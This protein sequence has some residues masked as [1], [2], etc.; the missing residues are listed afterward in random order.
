MPYLR[1]GEILPVK[2]QKLDI[3]S[4][5]L[6]EGYSFPE[7]MHYVRG[8]M[9]KRDGKSRIGTQTLGA[10]KILHL[11]TFE[12][13]TGAIRLMLHTPR[14]VMK[15]N[16][17]SLAFDDVTG[18]DLT[19]AETDPF[20]SC[21]VT[22]DDLY[23]F[24]NYVDAIRKYNDAGTTGLLGGSPP[25]A[26]CIEY[27]TP[28]VFIANLEE[29]G[30]AIPTKGRWCD[31]GNPEEWN[32][33]NAGS[34]LF[35]DDATAIRR[36]K[37]LGNSL[38]VYKQ[39][40]SYIGHIVSTADIF[41]FDKFATDRGLYSSRAIVDAD[42]CHYYM[43]SSDFHYN[44]GVRIVD[45]GKDVREYIF[46]RLNRTR[47]QTCFALHVELFKEVWFFITTTG[48]DWPTEI[49]KYKYDL[50]FWYKDTCSNIIT[51]CNY[52]VVSSRTWD[53]AVGSWNSQATSW[54]NQEGQADAPIQVLGN[55]SGH[56]LKRDS[57]TRDDD[58]AIVTGKVETSDYCGLPPA[59]GIVGIEN[60][61]EWMQFDFWASG[62]KVKIYYSL[63]LGE[64]WTYL[65]EKTLTSKIEKHTCYFQIVSPHIRFKVENADSEGQFTIRSWI[66]YYLDAAEDPNP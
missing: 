3:P 35:T 5:Y 27:I 63:D 33:G 15:Y 23:L 42:S 60:D 39:G 53:N 2:G 55:S 11:S 24:S 29:D 44:N 13:S 40:M 32:A 54:D 41:D 12:L 66:P 57:S 10:A 58:G 16:T 47:Y 25:K 43:G 62:S 19:G 34:Q 37:K 38:F 50:G 64:S 65:K 7:N 30:F 8:E 49:W 45:I 46:G 22:E 20:D 51:G 52:K 36:A 56:C 17:S 26:K 61:Q 9:R 18:V 59:E 6:P 48:N 21:T 1:K 14:N 31:T 4:I 28:Y